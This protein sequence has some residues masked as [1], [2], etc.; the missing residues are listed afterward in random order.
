MGVYRPLNT[1]V[2]LHFKL[3]WPQNYNATTSLEHGTTSGVA[4]LGSNAW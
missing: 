3:R 4:M 1:M 2:Q